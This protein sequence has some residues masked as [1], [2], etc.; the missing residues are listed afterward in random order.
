MTRLASQLSGL[1]KN[2]TEVHFFFSEHDI[3]EELLNRDAPFDAARLVKNGQIR[4]HKV[5]D[6]DHTFSAER[7]RKDFLRSFCATVADAGQG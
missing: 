7:A 4:I 1:A 6:A 2:G 3:G 5:A